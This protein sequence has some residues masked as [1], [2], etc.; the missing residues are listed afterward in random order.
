MWSI[1]MANCPPTNVKFQFRR[2]EKSE[3]D[4]PVGSLTVLR[5]GEP[6]FEADT[7]QLKIGYTGMP[8]KD[9]PYVGENDVAR[10]I[11]LNAYIHNATSNVTYNPSNNTITAVTKLYGN[12]SYYDLSF[13]LQIA[14]ATGATGTAG[15]TG[16]TGTAQ[17]APATGNLIN[18]GSIIFN[19]LSPTA[20]PST[21][22]N[23]IHYQ[24][25]NLISVNMGMNELL[26][27]ITTA[28]A[29]GRGR[30][31]TYS[32][33]ALVFISPPDPMGN[34]T[35]T[36]TPPTAPTI[37]TSNLI[38]ISGVRYYASG[39]TI[40]FPY[41]SL[42][43]TN[44]YN[45][46]PFQSGL[47]YNFL[48]ITNT[49]GSG[50]PPVKNTTL[51]HYNPGAIPF[52]YTNIPLSI[53]FNSA[54]DYIL[55]GSSYSFPITVNLTATNTKLLTGSRIYTGGPPYSNIGY[56]GSSWSPSFE[57]NIPPNLNG[58]TISGITRVTRVSISSSEV[59]PITPGTFQTFNPSSMT[60]YDPVYLPYNSKFYALNSEAAAYLAQTRM[61]FPVPTN[62][63]ST[64]FLSLEIENTAV[65][66]SFT[67]R[68]GRTTS[69]PT[70]QNVR[71]KWYESARNITYGWYNANVPYGDAGGCQN[72]VAN[73]FTY[74]IRINISNLLN[75]SLAAGA[76]GGKIWI[77]IQFSGVIS[78]NDISIL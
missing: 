6:G 69:I 67:L 20:A 77:N 53:Y 16:G 46:V 64:R 2:G 32:L 35:V 45:I 1:I 24:T 39:S 71:V 59:S 68:V 66:Q 17:I 75:Y 54:F 30:G 21:T 9:L 33:T 14:G 38:Q 40:G 55:Q 37:T 65:L 74:Q 19:N 47:P 4:G 10:N 61:P 51:I 12:S 52:S 56:V 23:R 11:G 13:R 58:P 41:E 60:T 31:S 63:N 49:A 44:I 8:W 27:D 15:S 22:G 7:G 48:S 76:G 43:F 29:G 73:A 28:N 25:M 18:N 50:S 78:L 70:I 26:I 42:V 36:I 57:T 34:P 62:T 3:W 5:D 72:G